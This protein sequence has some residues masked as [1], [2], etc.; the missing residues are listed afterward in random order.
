MARK[1]TPTDAADDFTEKIVD[2]DVT[3]PAPGDRLI[4]SDAPRNAAHTCQVMPGC[5]A[6]GAAR[7]LVFRATKASSAGAPK[8]ISS[9]HHHGSMIGPS[10][11]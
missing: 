7:R 10:S 9:C 2:I 1:P 3:A 8:R 4:A 6:R 5:Y 11:R